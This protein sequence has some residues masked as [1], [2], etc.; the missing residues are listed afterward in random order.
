MN[1]KNLANIRLN[2]FIPKYNRNK[3]RTFKRQNTSEK[4]AMPSE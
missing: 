2:S 4:T 3:S 1:A